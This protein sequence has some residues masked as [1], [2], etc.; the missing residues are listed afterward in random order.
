MNAKWNAN[1]KIAAV[2]HPNASAEHGLQTCNITIATARM[3]DKR[4]M[5]VEQIVSLNCVKIH[6]VP[7]ILCMGT[8][9]DSLQMMRDEL[10][11]ENE[12]IVITT[13][14]KLLVNISTIRERSQNREICSPLKV[15]VLK[16]SKV[17]QSIARTWM[18]TVGEW[19]QVETYTSVSPDNRCGMGSV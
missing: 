17:A 13:Q 15:L 3:V 19:Y 6:L 18:K 8:G 7:L 9:T 5:D 12:G 11:V 16:G 14:V 2:T 10:E 4:I 1:G